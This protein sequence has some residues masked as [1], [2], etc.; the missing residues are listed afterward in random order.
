MELSRQLSSHKRNQTA[1]KTIK[2]LLIVYVITSGFGRL[3]HGF[4][5]FIEVIAEETLFRYS[6]IYAYF[7]MIGYFMSFL[8]VSNNV[9]NIF[10]YIKMIPDFRRFL[11]KIFSF[12]RC[13]REQKRRSLRL[14]S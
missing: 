11:L 4:A 8:A 9:L 13:G 1:L 3:V 7:Q 2:Y 14:A 12:G 10:V 5:V 6:K